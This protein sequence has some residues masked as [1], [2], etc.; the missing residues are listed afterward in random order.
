MT[1]LGNRAANSP[2]ALE[3]PNAGGLAVFAER[4]ARSGEH[5]MLVRPR[6]RGCSL[7]PRRCATGGRPSWDTEIAMRGSAPRPMRRLPGGTVTGFVVIALTVNAALAPGF[8]ATGGPH[9]HVPA[10]YSRCPDARA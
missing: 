2:P 8:A 1:L 4:P 10:G 5:G 6:I 7:R 9:Y 3:R